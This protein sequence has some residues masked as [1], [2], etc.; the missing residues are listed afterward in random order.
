MTIPPTS[1]PAVQADG[2][3][4]RFTARPV[5][6]EVSF[7]IEPGEVVGL[8]GPN[9]SGK[10]TTIRMLLGLL[11]PDAGR[12][13]M[14]GAEPGSEGLR[15]A[16]YLPEERGLYRE[17]R[18]GETVRYLATLK[19]L[20]RDAAE[21]AA[22]ATLERLGFGAFFDRPLKT[23]SRGQ[24]QMIGFA[25]TVAHGPRLLVMDE[26]FSGLDPVHNRLM[27][28]YL[29]GL[30]AAGTAIL[31]S[32][33]QMD[34][35]E[36]LCSRVVMLEQGEVVLEGPVGAVRRRFG[37]QVLEVEGTPD[38]TAEPMGVV[39]MQRAGP[40]LRMHLAPGA[41]PEAVLR[42]LLDEGVRVTRFAVSTPS[43]EEVFIRTVQERRMEVGRA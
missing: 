7:A 37:T 27:K 29:A 6:R 11:T 15:Q 9:G 36:E 24:A 25:A 22:R 16:G 5:V 23:L 35:V 40:A 41:A 19:G 43:L 33:H 10:S 26:P 32:T 20:T 12:A 39:S 28:E 8:V 31:L 14:F 1:A 21:Q 3:W 38:P 13:R 2:L 42:A 17:E 18:A 30:R 34:D 4:K